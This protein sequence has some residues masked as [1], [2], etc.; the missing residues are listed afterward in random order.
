MKIAVFLPNWVGDVVM[1]TPA[2]RAM[3]EHFE[4]AHITAVLKPYV[5]EVLESCPWID[6]WLPA[7]DGTWSHGIVA[8]AARLRRRGVD[9][10]VLFPNSFRTAWI[11]WLGRCR[12]RIGYARHGRS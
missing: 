11:A 7:G 3:R 10:A 5:A 12:R 9:L 4:D 1:T 8:T 6:E 2:L